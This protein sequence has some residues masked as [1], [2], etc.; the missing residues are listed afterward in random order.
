MTRTINSRKLPKT[1]T[2]PQVIP[3]LRATVPS[4][5]VVTA[6]PTPAATPPSH[7]PKPK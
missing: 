7:T 4:E 1:D 2:A 6:Q 3:A 5:Q